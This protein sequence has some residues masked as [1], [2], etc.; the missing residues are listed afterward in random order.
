MRMRR[1]CPRSSCSAAAMACWGRLSRAGARQFS[2]RHLAGGSLPSPDPQL[3]IAIFFSPGSPMNTDPEQMVEHLPSGMPI[4]P[5]TSGVVRMFEEPG[6][7]FCSRYAGV[8]ASGWG[9][10]GL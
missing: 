7:R 2:R 3:R 6:V 1:C 10:L 8:G 4:R 9:A 5:P